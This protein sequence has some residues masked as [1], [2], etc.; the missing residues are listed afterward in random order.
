MARVA[1]LNDSIRTQLCKILFWQ[2]VII[3]GTAL[4]IGLLQGIQRGC[5]SLIG[6]LAY[7]VPTLIF[8]WRVSA[9][10]GARAATRFVIAFFGGEIVKL[11]LSGVLFVV[12]IKYLSIDLFYG[13]VGLIGA[14]IA[15]WIASA[16]CLLSSGGKA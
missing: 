12:A 11:I 14:I 9:H 2:L 8:L 5:S 1:K 3:M 15:F 4:V 7:W 6:G 16:T 10:A 13:V